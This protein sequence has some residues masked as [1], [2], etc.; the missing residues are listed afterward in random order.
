MKKTNAKKS[1]LFFRILVA[2][3]PYHFE[4]YETSI[5]NDMVLLFAKIQIDSIFSFMII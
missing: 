2:H 5:P 4:F 3:G 1:D